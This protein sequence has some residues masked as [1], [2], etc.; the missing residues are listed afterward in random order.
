MTFTKIVNTTY[1]GDE[2]SPDTVGVLNYDASQYASTPD[3]TASGYPSSVTVTT[4]EGPNSPAVFNPMSFPVAITC[5]GIAGQQYSIVLVYNMRDNNGYIVSTIQYNA[6]FTIP[7]GVQGCTDPSATNYNPNATVNDGSCIY[8]TLP[9]PP[10]GP[11][12]PVC[13]G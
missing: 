2:Y 12:P 9:P 8:P 5:P 7:S 10:P 11:G 4:A 3:T 6:Y 1:G 13:T